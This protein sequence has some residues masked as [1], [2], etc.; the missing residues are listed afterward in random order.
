MLFVMCL[1]QCSLV[2]A[3]ADIGGGGAGGGWGSSLCGG[4][5]GSGPPRG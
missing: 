3:G 5:V 4:G 1:P 2:V